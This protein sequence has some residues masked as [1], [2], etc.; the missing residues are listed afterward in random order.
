MNDER[1]PH[2]NKWVK[3]PGCP[4]VRAA[5]LSSCRAL[6][7]SATGSGGPP[8]PAGSTAGRTA[9]EREMRRTTDERATMVAGP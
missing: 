6:R 8:A 9:G 3:P 4:V 2:F 5:C 7:P 1:P